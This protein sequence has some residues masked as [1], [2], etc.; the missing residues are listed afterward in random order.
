MQKDV[1]LYA[2]ILFGMQM[3]DRMHRNGQLEQLALYARQLIME[4][5][6]Q[7]KRSI[8]L[9]TEGHDMGTGL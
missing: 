4:R 8:A 5:Y 7:Q 1:F 2:D 9:I 6:H 3:V